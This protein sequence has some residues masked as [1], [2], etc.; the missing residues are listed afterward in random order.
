MMPRVTNGSRVPQ[1]HSTGIVMLGKC[2]SRNWSGFPGGCNGYA[3]SS[4]PLAAKPDAASI[5][6]ARPPIDR[7]PITRRVG[8]S[9][10]RVRST[11]AAIV[12]CNT[13]I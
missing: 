4:N 1:K 6:A 3:S 9:S 7:P 2:A 8:C 13:G 11:T 12:S 5:D 10:A